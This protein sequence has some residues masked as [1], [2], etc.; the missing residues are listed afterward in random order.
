MSEHATDGWI[1]ASL[2]RK[3]DERHLLGVGSFVGDIRLPGLQDIAFVR[4]EVAHGVLKAVRKPADIASRVFTISDLAWLKVLEAGPEL[5][6]FRSSPYPALA[7]EKVRYVGQT[8][9][10]CVAP[11]RALAEDLAERVEV[12]IETLPAVTDCVA[13][14]R[15]DSA[16]LFDNWP[17]N[18]FIRSTVMDGDPGSLARAPIRLHRQFRM[19]RQATVSLEGRGVVAYRDH[20]LDRKD[21]DQGHHGPDQGPE[22][23]RPAHRDPLQHG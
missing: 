22:T 21:D 19:N 2:L 9:A 13:A 3:E 4:S 5:V 17:D 1:G 16:R 6:A 10:A 12:E 7:N 23:T 18:A 8:I 14:M 15:S 20:R 11:N